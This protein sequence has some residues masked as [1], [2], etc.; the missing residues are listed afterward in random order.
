VTRQPVTPR[1]VLCERPTGG[2]LEVVPICQDHA[3]Y[4][5]VEEEVRAMREALKRWV[6]TR[7]IDRQ[8][9]APGTWEAANAAAVE[10][11][12]LARRA[13]GG[14]RRQPLATAG[15]APGQSCT[16]D[17]GEPSVCGRCGAT[18]WHF[19]EEGRK[20]E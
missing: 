2:L 4:G 13:L 3:R 5:Q 11:E 8:D 16:Y 6:E 9:P 15:S 17:A 12:A 19:C 18:G 7:E 14:E 10:L 1:C 20:G